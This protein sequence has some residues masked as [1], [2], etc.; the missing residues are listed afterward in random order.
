LQDAEYE[1]L[2]FTP[3]DEAA[4]RQAEI[5]RYKSLNKQNE[6]KKFLDR[7]KAKRSKKKSK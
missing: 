2:E 7:K 5:E 4:E 6:N 3:D 1:V